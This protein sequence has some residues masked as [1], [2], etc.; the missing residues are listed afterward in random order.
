M[1]LVRSIDFRITRS[2]MDN[3]P[4]VFQVFLLGR[5]FQVSALRSM[6]STSKLEQWASW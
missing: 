1:I 3:H 2:G 5:T 4:S 6:H